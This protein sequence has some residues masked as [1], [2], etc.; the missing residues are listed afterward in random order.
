[1]KL[2]DIFPRAVDHCTKSSSRVKH[3][4][5]CFK[6]NFWQLSWINRL[7]CKTQRK[8]KITSW[9]WCIYHI[10]SIRHKKS[11]GSTPM[12]VI[13]LF[14]DQRKT[15]ASVWSTSTAEFMPL[16]LRLLINRKMIAC[17]WSFSSNKAKVHENVAGLGVYVDQ[18]SASSGCIKFTFSC[19]KLSGL[20]IRCFLPQLD[21]LVNV[22][23]SAK[24]TI[25]KSFQYGS[26][27][28]E[29]RATWKLIILKIRK[30][31]GERTGRWSQPVSGINGCFLA[32]LQEKHCA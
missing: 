1:M 13:R 10:P 23:P 27:P 21:R 5:V 20:L 30:D 4:R 28:T 25:N 8:S 29:I 16:Y 2:W 15:I 3:S 19:A 32:W 22:L 24:A 7:T 14:G 26:T 17:F 9:E 12:H 11:Y 31:T 6:L 18:I